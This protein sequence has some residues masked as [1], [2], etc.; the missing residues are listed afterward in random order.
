MK[1]KIIADKA[2]QI[3]PNPPK[4]MIIDDEAAIA[5][6]SSMIL[7]GMGYDVL[8]AATSPKEAL[9]F[10]LSNQ[11]NL[12]D[13]IITDFNM[14]GMNALGLISEVRRNENLKG[15]DFIVMSGNFD[16]QDQVVSNDSVGSFILKPFDTE[17]L[18][19]EIFHVYPHHFPERITERF[20]RLGVI[21]SEV[22]KAL[23]TMFAN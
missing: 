19:E 17:R 7:K 11:D 3:L 4:I 1:K 12:P 2:R 20:M 18:V 5:R 23:S 13:V 14:P 8:M 16:N 15:I 6:V 10:L 21:E 9:E 22:V